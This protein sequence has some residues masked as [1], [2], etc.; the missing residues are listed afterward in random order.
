MGAF[1]G[2]GFQPV[3]QNFSKG[4]ETVLNGLDF[5]LSVVGHGAYDRPGDDLRLRIVEQRYL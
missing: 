1:V 4:V 3:P 2:K 5:K